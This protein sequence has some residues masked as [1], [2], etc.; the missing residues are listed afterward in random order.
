MLDGPRWGPASRGTPRQLVVLLH[1]VGA[2]GH[3]LINLAPHWG[4]ALPDAAFVS[5]DAPERYDQAPMGRQWFSLADRT[6]EFIAAGAARAEPVLNA[7]I[8][9]E[10][11]RLGIATLAIAGFSQGAMMA[12]YAGLRRASAPAA[13]VAFSGA[14][15]S[16]P[17]PVPP[18]PVLLVHGVEDNVV[19]VGRSEQAE[20][21]LKA[22]GVPVQAI[23]RPRLTHAIDEELD[24]RRAAALMHRVFAGCMTA[25]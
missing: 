17:T 23:Y 14:L 13:I 20:K 25:P 19:P 3:D 4:A 7:S 24:S 10:L 22:A 2:D 16:L 6:P 21:L 9:A 11:A 18:I 5:F 8:D 12:L 15:L 1:G